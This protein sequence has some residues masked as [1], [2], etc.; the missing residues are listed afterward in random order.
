M[1]RG[2]AP[3]QDGRRAWEWLNGW[4]QRPYPGAVRCLDDALCIE[5]RN[6]LAGAARQATGD[7][8]R[9]LVGM[10]ERAMLHGGELQAGAVSDAWVVRARLPVPHVTVGAT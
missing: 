10:R 1:S 4:H 5:V 3:W 8:G 7:T 2:R 9:G 6:P